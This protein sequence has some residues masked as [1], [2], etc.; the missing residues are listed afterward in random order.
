MRGRLRLDVAKGNHLLILI[1]NGGG[2]FSRDDFFKQRLAH[3]PRQAAPSRRK[4]QTKGKGLLDDQGAIPARRLQREALAK[5]IHDLILQGSAART[6]APGA[7]E[8]FDAA[9]QSAKAH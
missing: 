9:A 8:L 4:D 3:R 6:P 2:D 1:Q 5:I 7:G